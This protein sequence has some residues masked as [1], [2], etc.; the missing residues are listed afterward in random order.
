MLLIYIYLSLWICKLRDR[1]DRTNQSSRALSCEEARNY[2]RTTQPD[3][4]EGQ[5]GG[6]ALVGLQVGS[7]EQGTNDGGGFHIAQEERHNTS[8]RARNTAV[9][10]DHNAQ[11][12]AIL[13]EDELGGESDRGTQDHR[14]EREE[15]GDI[16][17]IRTYEHRNSTEET[18]N[19]GSKSQSGV[20]QESDIAE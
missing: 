15:N 13:A 14:A 4:V 19:I 10:L 12:D 7:S 1:R 8:D 11:D 17:V 6:T 3:L 9:E 18:E 16:G 5:L 20:V 2:F